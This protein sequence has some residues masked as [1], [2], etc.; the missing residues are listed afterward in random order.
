MC[1]GALGT[2]GGGSIRLPAGQMGLVGLKPT[3]GAVP[4]REI[5][6]EVNVVGILARSAQDVAAMYGS[7]ADG[8]PGGT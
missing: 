4:H 2:D 7:V 8:S 5:I 3:R 1:F 6:S